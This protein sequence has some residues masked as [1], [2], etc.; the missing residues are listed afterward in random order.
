[1]D[2]ALEDFLKSGYPRVVLPVRVGFEAA[3]S[4]FF[5]RGL[6]W[7]GEG[8]PQINDPLYKPIVEE[9][10]ERTGGDQG[11]I[12]VGEP[13]ETRLPTA[14]ILVRREASLPEWER[15]DPNK[16]QWRPKPL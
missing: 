7:E 16:W 9:I 11:E 1:M 8:E 13:W 14:A 15:I 5:E 2:P 6:V 3:V 10:K 4:Y 12:A